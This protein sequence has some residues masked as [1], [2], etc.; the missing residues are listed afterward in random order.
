MD[1]V[2]IIE[3]VETPAEV[4]TEAANAGQETPAEV[5]TEGWAPSYKFKVYD[6]EMEFP[7][8][9]RA[10]IKDGD[11]EK[12]FRELFEKAYALDEHK[13]I[14]Q[15]VLG[16]LDEYKGQASSV[17]GKYDQTL[18]GVKRI[19]KMSQTDLDSFFDVYK[20][21]QQKIF[22]WARQKLSEG[23]LPPEEQQYRQSLRERAMAASNYEI[24]LENMK[25]QNQSM[26]TQQ[27]EMNM[28]AALSSQEASS[29]SAQFDSRFGQG[30]FLQHV[31]DYGAKA[32]NLEKRYAS[33]YEA[34]KA[35]MQYYGAAI[36]TT[37]S[38]TTPADNGQKPVIPNVGTGRGSSP[39]KPKFKNLDQMKKYVKEHYIE[40]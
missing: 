37:P 23:D 34:V 29:F 38:Q 22:E 16:N 8:E 21:P 19:Y 15:K 1:T 24:E 14:H 32:Y 4:A 12:K 5:T 20:I 6:K 17:Q 28:Q 36:N 3:N 26:I 33:P 27:H 2:E 11:T 25:R 35:V 18:D 13:K 9:Y 10:Y 7:E 31:Q 30:A 40:G 39:V